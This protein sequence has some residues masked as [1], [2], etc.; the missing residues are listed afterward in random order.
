MGFLRIFKK[1]RFLFIVGFYGI[2]IVFSYYLSFLLRFDFSISSHSPFILKTLL[3]LIFIKIC[4]FYYFGLFHSSLRHV[5]IFDLWQVIK[6]NSIA[7]VGFF[8]VIA[9]IYRMTGYPRSIFIL[10]WGIC[11]LLIG[12]FKFSGRLLREKKSFSLKF[13]NKKVLIVGAGEAGNLVL[14]ECRKNPDMKLSVAG[15]ID[16]SVGKRNL[17][18]QGVKIFGSREKIP[19]VV[20]KYGIE[21]IIIAIPSAEGEAIRGILGYCQIEGVKIKIVPGIYKILNGDLEIKLRDVQPEDLLGRKMVDID[22]E[23]IKSYI[24]GKIVLITG[25]GGSIGSELSRQIA[26]FFPQKL[27]LWDHNENDIYFLERELQTSYPNLCLEVIIGDIKDISLL[28]YVFSKLK[29]QIVFHAAAFKHVPLMEKNVAA[30]FKNNVIGSRNLIYAAEHYKSERFVL[31]STD[32]A[33]NPTSVMGATKRVVEMI[34]QAKAKISKTKFMAVRFGNVLG[35][36]GSVVPFFKKQIEGGGPITVT[37]PDAMRYFMSVHEAVRLVLQAGVI[38][39]GGEIFIL[40]MGE[41]IKIVDLAKN[42]IALSGLKLEKDIS[43]KFI[44]LRPGEKLCEETL[45]DTERD[46]TTK[47]NKIYITQPNSFDSRKL[48]QQIKK[49]EKLIKIRDEQEIIKKIQEIVPSFM[50]DSQHSK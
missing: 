38:G 41:Q 35:S 21:E 28:K 27:I 12:G 45:H 26:C 17:Q 49:I 3:I 22:E 16:D 10:D 11:L 2:L 42:L 20:D 13:R 48:N 24:G 29:P 9:F 1:F 30:A 19:E 44:G 15:F 8:L 39:K 7:S 40:D 37:H 33:V 43:I 47:H 25:A 4:V 18:I 50:P 36:N 32:K 46:K 5:S 6:A 23:E 14:E 34:L 31:I